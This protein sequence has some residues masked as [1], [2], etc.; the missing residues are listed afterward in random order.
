MKETIV[1]ITLT[2]IFSIVITNWVSKDIKSCTAFQIIHSGDVFIGKNFD[3]IVGD[4]LLFVNKREMLKKAIPTFF[5]KKDSSDQLV[6][7]VSKYG[8]VTYNLFG[9]EFGLGGMNEAGLVIESLS[10]SDTKTHKPDARP[11]I[12]ALQFGQ[13][14]LDNYS[15]VKDV[16]ESGKSIRIR[17][18]IKPAGHMFVA[19]KNGNSAVI[20]Y[21]KGKR[22]Y[23]TND[24]MPYKALT[25]SAYEKSIGYYKKNKKPWRDEGKSIE[26]FI[27]TANMLREYGTDSLVSPL[28]Y[29]FRILE[30]TSWKERI[31]I[32][33]L[34]I[35]ME[36][37]WSFVYDVNRLQIYFR[38][39]DNQNLRIINLK[40]FDFS[41]S[42]PVKVLDI[43]KPLSGDVT[44]AFSDYTPQINNKFVKN[45]F[46]KTPYPF[47]YGLNFKFFYHLI[48]SGFSEFPEHPPENIDT[49]LT[50]PDTTVCVNRHK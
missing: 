9:R 12:S 24:S 38:T 47:I 50:Y 21:I 5:D 19:D 31:S 28:D 13:Y 7:W 34:N 46:K 42:T 4:G 14:L 26:R 16:I 25:N 10:F 23:Y 17:P 43:N 44:E 41:C 35:K 18:T 20:E 37:K 30:E 39:N 22:V 8:S 49:L 3:W 11:S 2:I 27:V 6:S 45:I 29:S 1:L 36:T 32:G 33:K 15:S 40:S 48:K